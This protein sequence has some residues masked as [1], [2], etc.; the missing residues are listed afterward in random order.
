MCRR[1][2]CDVIGEL[3][4]VKRSSCRLCSMISCEWA[5]L[6][7]ARPRCAKLISFLCAIVYWTEVFTNHIYG[8]KLLNSMHAEMRYELSADQFSLH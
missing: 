8:E 1:R 7:I 5:W 3:L 2:M 4:E 6:N